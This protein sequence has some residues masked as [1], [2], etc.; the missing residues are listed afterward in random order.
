MPR[1]VSSACNLAMRRLVILTNVP[2]LARM[3]Q[4]RGVEPRPVDL[5]LLVTDAVA[6]FQVVSPTYPVTMAVEQIVVAGDRM[7]LR[8][9]V[10]N[11]L[12]NVRTHTPAGTA[13]SISLRREGEMALLS[14]KDNG[15]GVAMEDQE[16]IFERFWRADKAR[17]RS[18]GGSGLGLAIV[19]S[20]VEA[21]GGSITIASRPGHGTTFTVTLPIAGPA[22][23]ADA[24]EA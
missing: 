13:V 22:V 8:Q 19:A 1:R 6:D 11:L 5:A 24:F 7:R 12:S 15:P 16:H 23:D 10:D 20:L 18:K 9:V 21:H 2:L 17:T 4:A 3:D 14:V